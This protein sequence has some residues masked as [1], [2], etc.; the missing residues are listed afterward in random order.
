MG[1]SNLGSYCGKVLSALY[2]LFEPRPKLSTQHRIVAAWGTHPS[3]RDKILAI[4]AF[5]LGGRSTIERGDGTHR[6]R[7]E[8]QTE[9][10]L[11][12][13]AFAGD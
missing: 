13:G 12:D 7:V 2:L 9:Q 4:E 1:W 10:K 5:K 6:A 11:A 8:D 3:P